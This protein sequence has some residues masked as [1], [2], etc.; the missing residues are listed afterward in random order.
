MSNHEYIIKFYGI[1][2]DTKEKIHYLVME[3]A[4]NGNLRKYLQN[5]EL[6]WPEK[7]RIANTS[8]KGLYGVIPFIDPRKLQDQKYPY[9]KKSDVYSTGVLIWEI[10]SNGRLPFEQNSDF[11]L[12]INIINGSREDPVTGTP[13]QYIDLYSKC[14]DYEPN[15][16]PSMS[17][18]IHQLSS[19][20]LDPKYD[21]TN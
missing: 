17:E 20:K 7:I 15:K 6:E 1:S 8:S 9:D 2:L 16:R 5:N 13:K 3:Y 14:W 10:S 4:N 12:P 18:I 21:G 19:L 11:C